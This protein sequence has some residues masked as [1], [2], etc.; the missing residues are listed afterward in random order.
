MVVFTTRHSDEAAN[1]GRLEN[2]PTFV[3]SLCVVGQATTRIATFGPRT[4][5][6]RHCGMGIGGVGRDGPRLLWWII[7]SGVPAKVQSPMTNTLRYPSLG[8]SIA[9]L[10]F[11]GSAIR[12]KRCRSNL[13]ITRSSMILIDPASACRIDR[14]ASP[15]TMTL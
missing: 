6:R 11:A 15:S 3:R 10:P 4:A 5:F 12:R 8:P 14:I 2:D 7:R 9:P 1:L 13:A